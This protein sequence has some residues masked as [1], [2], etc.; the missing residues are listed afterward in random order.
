MNN[1]KIIELIKPNFYSRFNNMH[2]KGSVVIYLKPLIEIYK[3]CNEDALPEIITYVG[4][5][6]T[7][8]LELSRKIETEDPTIISFLD[9]KGI[10]M[11]DLTTKTK[12]LIKDKNKIRPRSSC[13]REIYWH[14]INYINAVFLAHSRAKRSQEIKPTYFDV[15]ILGI[16]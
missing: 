7:D 13:K 12:K 6:V 14:S 3:L 11:S 1:E 10:Y 16:S 8:A 15:Y 2:K 9:L 4:S 5:V